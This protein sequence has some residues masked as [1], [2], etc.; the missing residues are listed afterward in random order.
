MTKNG[1]ILINGRVSGDRPTNW[2]FLGHTGTTVIDLVFVKASH[3]HLVSDLQ[4]LKC[5][6]ASGPD[7]IT[8]EFY[9]ALPFAGKLIMLNLFNTVIRKGVLQ[10]ETLSALLFILYISDFE[11]FLGD[12]NLYGLNID[13]ITDI[14]MLHYADD[15]VILVDSHIKLERVL[16]I[17]A[18]YCDLNG[19]SVNVS[20]T[21]IMVFKKSGRTRK[22]DSR[23]RLYKD[24]ELEEAKIYM[25]LGIPVNRN[26]LGNEAARHAISKAKIATSVS[27]KGLYSLG[28]SSWST[29]VTLYNALVS[30]TLFYAIPA[31]GLLHSGDLE[32]AQ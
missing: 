15:T 12:R 8:N 7:L 16:K 28:V 9:K 21:K 17:L 11:K 25:Y 3:I 20:K 18:E 19:L 2:T 13:G 14:L 4:K 22:L 24:S 10:G 29:Y 32:K 6:K 26:A 1:H 27:L 23:L 30:S 31:W 5:N